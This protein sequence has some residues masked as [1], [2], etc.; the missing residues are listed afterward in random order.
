MWFHPGPR[1][2]A[3]QVLEERV[4]GR[5]LRFKMSFDNGKSEWLAE[6]EL[7]KEH[8]HLFREWKHKTKCDS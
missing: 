3:I 4:I 7:E 8:P 6:E 1:P 2:S 5:Q